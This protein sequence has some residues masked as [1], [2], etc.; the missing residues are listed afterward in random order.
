MFAGTEPNESD[1][2]KWKSLY[3]AAGMRSVA[4]A[5]TFFRG[6]NFEPILIKGWAAAR[7]YPPDVQRLYTD[8]DLS[9]R[10]SDVA[11]ATH[12]WSAEPTAGL[13][14]DFHSELRHLDC[15]DWDDLFNNS[16]LVPLGGDSIRVLRP[17][18]HLRVLCVHFLTDGAR[19]KDR[20][21]DIYYAV[22]RREKDFDW[23]R[24]LDI[25]PPNRRRWVV[26]VIGLAH[27]YLGLDIRS[28]PFEK[29]AQN[30]PHWFTRAVERQ[31]TSGQKFEY[32]QN[33]MSDPRHF[34]RQL[35]KRIPPEPIFAT[36]D[37]NGSID[38]RIRMHYRL[39][40]MMKRALP[41][42]R[43]VVINLVLSARQK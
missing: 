5:F 42:T 31:W 25:V 11:A 18:D 28:L 20:L 1:E 9:F 43:K 40:S 30:L 35:A 16:I 41:A 37:M 29:D 13:P 2:L 24:C 4:E 32:L 33:A 14:V 38:S 26:C 39:G 17:E 22:D 23:G 19:N 21:W 6:H 27:K 12:A 3:A 8:I 7:N 36:I 15:V 34:F 10:A